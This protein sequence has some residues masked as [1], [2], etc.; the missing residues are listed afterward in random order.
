MGGIWIGGKYIP[1]SLVTTYF[2]SFSDDYYYYGYRYCKYSPL[3]TC[4]KTP[5]S[6]EPMKYAAPEKLISWRW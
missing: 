1:C 3:P 5:E 6:L 4:G 2:V